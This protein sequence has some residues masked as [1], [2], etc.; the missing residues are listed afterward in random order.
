MMYA[1]NIFF[2]AVAIGAGA[3]IWITLR[4]SMT[5]VPVLIREM[6]GGSQYR[7]CPA[8]D[9]GLAQWPT[10]SV[11]EYRAEFAIS[12]LTKGIEKQQD[13]TPHPD[14]ASLRRI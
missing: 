3:T 2:T 7:I 13:C 4:Q 14:R 1:L 12:P 10:K 8:H 6:T 9:L 11:R 5:T